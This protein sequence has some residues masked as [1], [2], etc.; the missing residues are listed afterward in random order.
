MPAD[1]APGDVQRARR[2]SFTALGL[3]I[4]VIAALCVFALYAVTR[5]IVSNHAHA[6]LLQSIDSDLAG[7]VDLYASSG[8]DELIARLKDRT[9]LLASQRD[10]DFYLLANASG[11]NLV[12][13]L[14]TWP[15]LSAENSE[16]GQIALEG[17]APILARATQIAP[18]LKLVVGRSMART[19][20]L[21]NRVTLGFGA[22][23]L[24]VVAVAVAFGLGFAARTRKRIDAINTTFRLIGTGTL[25]ARAQ[26]S[27]KADEIDEL[28]KHT[29][30]MLER[31]NKLMTDHRNV[32]DH[33][34]HEIRTPL[35]H[36]DTRLLAIVKQTEGSSLAG[37]ISQARQHIK[38]IVAMLESLL[39]IAAQEAHAGSLIGLEPL[40]F[41]ALVREVA[42]LYED[43][44]EDMGF[45]FSV[46]IEDG[47]TLRGEKMQLTRLITNLLDNAFKYCGPD[48]KVQLSLREGPVLTVQDSGPGIPKEERE[49]I[50][51]RFERTQQSRSEAAQTTRKGTGGHGLGLA[52]ARAI[53]ER[54]GL[55]LDCLDSN[56]G[57]LFSLH[58]P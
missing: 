29:N 45:G 3:W 5:T 43:T 38:Y 2:S 26:P 41:S 48:G 50:F 24:A 39:D 58:R 46:D 4:A 14:T 21:L 18:T 19:Q 10:Q 30:V 22:A 37:E 1:S 34:A 11:E 6:V 27:T 16:V 40:D 52:L 57:A 8:E 15:L 54:H 9:A 31:I 20:Q 33:T 42:E 51:N 53:A 32:T 13:N 12:G 25:T 55:A 49:R 23:G 28:T 7:L 47:I 56:S 44:A 35:M 17:A 36:L